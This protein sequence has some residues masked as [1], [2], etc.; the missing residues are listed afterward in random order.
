MRAIP[1]RGRPVSEGRPPTG[2]VHLI[3]NTRSGANRRRGFD[4]LERAAAAAGVPHHRVACL[5]ELDE[6]ARAC[7]RDGCRLLVLNAGDSSVCRTLD[8]IRGTGW[9]DSEPD[10]ALLPGGTTN[11]IYRDVGMTG[12]PDVAL[13]RLLEGLHGDRLQCRRRRP[14][15]VRTG[16]GMTRHGFFLGTNA[17]VHA[18]LRSRERLQ[19]HVVSGAVSEPLSVLAMLWRLARRRLDTDP[20]LA[21]VDLE[22]AGADGRWRPQSHILLMAVALHRVILGLRPLRRGQGAGYGMLDWPDYALWPLLRGLL[23]G[24]LPALEQVSLRGR[25][26]WILDGEI[27]DHRP[28][29][30]ILAIDTA[31]PVRFATHAGP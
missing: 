18:T 21:P 29:D 25:F 27:Y 28:E 6:A 1:S 9:F 17:V 16:T 20:V 23:R 10:L 19:R 12:P 22:W 14:L 13:T 2:P 8:N 5:D 24:T 30:G 15:R 3:S 11:M 31:A 7:A 26:R 4:R